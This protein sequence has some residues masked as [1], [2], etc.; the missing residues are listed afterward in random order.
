M[1]L[2]V[3]SANFF[4]RAVRIARHFFAK[5][6]VICKS[7]GN[8]VVTHAISSSLLLGHDWIVIQ[9]VEGHLDIPRRKVVSRSFACPVRCRVWPPCSRYDPTQMPLG[10]MC[11][12][13]T[14]TVHRRSGTGRLLQANSKSGYNGVFLWLLGELLSVHWDVAL[15]RR[16]CGLLG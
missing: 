10:R 7:V 14:G 4:H 12:V 11:G 3:L 9:S 13:D 15:D 6:A 5:Q 16:R 2:S 8:A 1:I